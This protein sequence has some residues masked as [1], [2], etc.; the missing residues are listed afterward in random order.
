MQK[1]GDC[2]E[3]LCV[4]RTGYGRFKVARRYVTAHRFA[5]ELLVGPIP[6]DMTIDHVVCAN[7]L[8]VNPEHMEVV[9]L[10]ENTARSN[11]KR[12]GERRKGGG[13]QKD[14]GTAQ[15]VAHFESPGK[16]DLE[17]E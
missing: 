6:P 10:G 2:W 16:H 13:T 11:R 15:P 1:D 14:P 17:A 4:T 8:C 9:T 3:W 5:Y 7:R 12:R